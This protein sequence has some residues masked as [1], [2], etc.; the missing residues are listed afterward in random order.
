MLKWKTAIYLFYRKNLEDSSG[1]Q[2]GLMRLTTDCSLKRGET[3]VSVISSSVVIHF[4]QALVLP[5]TRSESEFVSTKLLQHNLNT[6]I[7]H[8]SF[9]LK[10]NDP[11]I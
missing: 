5:Q 7:V 10:F 2:I 8:P 4:L 3:G 6:T 1:D 11:Y 9:F